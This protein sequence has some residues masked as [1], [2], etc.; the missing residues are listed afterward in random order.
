MRIF[1]H[2]SVLALLALGLTHAPVWAQTPTEVEAVI[3]EAAA[4]HGANATQLVRVA[5]CES[6][7]RPWAVGRLGEQGIFQLHPRGLRP[8]FF[9]HGFD[10]VWD[11]VQQADFAAWAF[12]HGLARHW[13]CR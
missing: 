5:R 13:S 2:V 8:L 10:N 12:T 7:L 9:A 1:R 6:S 11:V 4:T 3:R